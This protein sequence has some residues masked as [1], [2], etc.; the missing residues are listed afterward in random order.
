MATGVVRCSSCARSGG[1]TQA[2]DERHPQVEDD[3]VG[4]A[5]LGLAQ[6]GFGAHRR[7]YLIPLEPQHPRKGLRDPSSSST[8]RILAR[9]LLG[10]RAIDRH[11]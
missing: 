7:P 1:G 10:S 9:R 11:D 4:M 8:M 5:F 3:G 2:V 6:A